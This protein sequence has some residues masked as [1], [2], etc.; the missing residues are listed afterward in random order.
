MSDD[1]TIQLEEHFGGIS[2]ALLLHECKTKK[3]RKN[4]LR[5]SDS[6]KSLLK[7][8]SSILLELISMYAHILDLLIIQPFEAG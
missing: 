7:R 4:S 2:L 5:Y 3:I 8:S 1:V 6:M